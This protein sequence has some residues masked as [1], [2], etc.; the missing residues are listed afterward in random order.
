MAVLAKHF[1]VPG[2]EAEK[3]PMEYKQCKRLV[4]GTFPTS[5]LSEI[6]EKLG[7]EYEEMM[8]NIVKLVQYML[9]TFTS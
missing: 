5:S 4:T 8:P 1:A 6:C 2:V 3:V 7:L 9:H